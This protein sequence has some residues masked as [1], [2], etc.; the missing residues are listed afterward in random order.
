MDGAWVG[1]MAAT[2]VLAFAVIAAMNHRRR[3]HHRA[4]LLRNLDHHDWC[5]WTHTPHARS[6]ATRK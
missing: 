6:P 2:F 1:I 5:K 4:E 3:E